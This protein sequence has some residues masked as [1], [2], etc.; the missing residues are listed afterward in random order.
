MRQSYRRRG[1]KEGEKSKE[2]REEGK[3]GEI[4]GGKSW[5]MYLGG[6]RVC[7]SDYGALGS[8]YNDYGAL[9]SIFQ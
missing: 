4:K 9:G 5:G 6:T 3:E 2:E 7:N 1:K 8:H